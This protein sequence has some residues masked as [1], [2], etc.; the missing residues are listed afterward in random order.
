[1]LLTR[2]RLLAHLHLLTA[3]EAVVGLTDLF[4]AG[5]SWACGWTHSL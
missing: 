5:R 4:L 2:R 3:R 1:M